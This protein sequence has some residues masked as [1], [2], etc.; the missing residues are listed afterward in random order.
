[1][2]LDERSVHHDKIPGDKYVN[3]AGD[4]QMR[5]WDYIV[6]PSA[7]ADEDGPITITLPPVA[8]ARG[9]F[10]SIVVRD[11]DAF[12]T[13]TVADDNDSECWIQDIVLNSKCDKLLLYSD[14]LCWH[15]GPYIA[16]FPGVA[17]TEAPETTAAPTTA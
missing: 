6:R 10:Y 12:N 13:V 2:A 7:S 11:A 16:R 3:P 9:R 5:T 14:G 1:M 8:D 4:Y 17:T 15:V